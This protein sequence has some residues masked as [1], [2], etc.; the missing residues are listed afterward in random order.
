ML[1]S[2][3]NHAHILAKPLPSS[4]KIPQTLT[5]KLCW[6]YESLQPNDGQKEI[7]LGT[8]LE[9]PRGRMSGKVKNEQQGKKN[10][11]QGKK[12]E[13]QGNHRTI[14][15]KMISKKGDERETKLIIE[16]EM[17]WIVKDEVRWS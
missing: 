2:N 11:R 13:R 3:P 8:R 5:T 12:N 7:I 9:R 4:K 1:S 15:K 10:E 17:K 14:A 16:K 6:I